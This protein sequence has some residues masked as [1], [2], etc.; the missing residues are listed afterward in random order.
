[1]SQKIGNGVQVHLSAT[2]PVSYAAIGTIE[3]VSDIAFVAD[4]ISKTF[5]GNTR[6][7]H[8]AGLVE[9]G[10]L[11]FT[12]F[13]Q[14]GAGEDADDLF[15]KVATG[16]AY[17][18]RVYWPSTESSTLYEAF[19]FQAEVGSWRLQVP[20]ENYQKVVV[21]LYIDGTTVAKYDPMAIA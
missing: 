19:E 10:D 18:W 9:V 15:D 5:H 2:S 17:W 20:R 7:R 21:S 8:G 1:M 11:E 14:S 6:K 12:L 4:R 3:E 13:H 16:T